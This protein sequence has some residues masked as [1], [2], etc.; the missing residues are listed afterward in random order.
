MGMHV[1]NP[2][3]RYPEIKAHFAFL[4]F[5]LR[6]GVIVLY[7]QAILYFIDNGFTLRAFFHFSHDFAM[8]SLT[9]YKY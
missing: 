1:I 3:V 9:F 8:K 6:H 4:P 2:M 5:V 7:T